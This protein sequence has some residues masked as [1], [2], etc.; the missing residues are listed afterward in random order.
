MAQGDGEE[1]DW[2]DDLVEV[3]RQIHAQVLIVAGGLAGEHGS[4]VE[5][6]CARPFQTAFGEDLYSTPYERASA[7]FHSIIRDHAFVDGNKRTAT[8]GAIRFLMMSGTI[9]EPTQLQVALL[10]EVALATASP[11]LDV[12]AIADWMRRIFDD[13][14]T[15]HTDRDTSLSD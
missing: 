10:G 1:I 11:G 3:V 8:V 12:P 14:L 15:G 2:L 9:D 5:A 13:A 6:A 7:F 4:A